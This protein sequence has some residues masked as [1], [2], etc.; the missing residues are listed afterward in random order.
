MVME[1]TPDVLAHLDRIKKLNSGNRYF[2]EKEKW[3][4]DEVIRTLEV[5]AN[6]GCI[7]EVNTKGFY[8]GDIEDTYPSKWIL[9][10]AN[11]LGI[12][13]HLA[14]D[15]HHPDHIRS[16]FGFGLKQLQSVGYRKTMVIIDHYWQ[17][18]L[19]IGNKIFIY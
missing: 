4:R 2:N 8:Y 15:A 1:G 17:D 6:K 16:G 14:S 7:V 19:L 9:Q 5:V 10:I 18:S 3:Y 11:D 13:T 12:G